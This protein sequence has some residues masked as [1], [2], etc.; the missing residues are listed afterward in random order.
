M[1]IMVARSDGRSEG[2]FVVEVAPGVP[3]TPAAIRCSRCYCLHMHH[4][5]EP[6]TSKH[7]QPLANHK[8]ARTS[9]GQSQASTHCMNHGGGGMACVHANNMNNVSHLLA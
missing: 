2:R 6:I 8:Q 4:G 5:C 3:A 1:H 9:I 7:T